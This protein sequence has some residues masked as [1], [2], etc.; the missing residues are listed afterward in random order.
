MSS[1]DDSDYVLAEN[2]APDEIS[3]GDTIVDVLTC[4]IAQLSDRQID[5]MTRQDLEYL[6]RVTERQVPTTHCA[7]VIEDLSDLRSVL[8]QLR[9]ECQSGEQN[10][11]RET[12]A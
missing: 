4:S 2:Y 3:L 8:K 5:A 12:R 11:D 1:E 10:G 9:D 7:Q 6:L